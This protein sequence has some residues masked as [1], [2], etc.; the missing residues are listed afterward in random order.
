MGFLDFE[1]HFVENFEKEEIENKKHWCK[2]H[3]NKTCDKCNNYMCEINPD[4]GKIFENNIEEGK[5]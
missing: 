3:F 1:S 5:K 2:E 4:H